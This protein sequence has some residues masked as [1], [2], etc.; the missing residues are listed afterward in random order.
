TAMVTVMCGRTTTSSMGRTGRSSDLGVFAM[1]QEN[2]YPA[3]GIPNPGL[4]LLTPLYLTLPPEGGRH[5][6]PSAPG[7]ASGGRSPPREG[8]DHHRRQQDHAGDDVLPGDVRDPLQVEAV[9]DAGDDQDA[10][11][12]V[13]RLVLRG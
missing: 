7:H 2:V 5:P 6:S 3:R 8:V 1:C 11:H 9:V 13:D 4:G 12:A 10:E